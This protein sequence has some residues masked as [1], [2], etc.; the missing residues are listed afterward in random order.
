MNARKLATKTALSLAN[1]RRCGQATH[2][3]HEY[4]NSDLVALLVRRAS[5][6]APAEYSSRRRVNVRFSPEVWLSELMI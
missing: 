1:K 6:S 2:P 4:T 3:L 5:I